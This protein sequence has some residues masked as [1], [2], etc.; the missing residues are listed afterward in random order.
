MKKSCML[1][2]ILLCTTVLLSFSQQAPG[3]GTFIIH[4]E[5]GALIGNS[6]N[7]KKSP[8]IFHSSLNYMLCKNLSAGIGTGVEFLK[9]T[10]LPVTANVLYQFRKNKAIFPFVRLQAGYQVALESATVMDNYNDYYYYSLSS[11]ASSF[12]PYPYYP[13]GEKLDAQG[14]WMINPSV[15]IIVYTHAGLGFSLAAGYRY[16]QLNYAGKDDYTFHAEY[17]RLMLA[18]GITF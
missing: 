18:F 5:G 9:E 13:W 12:Y 15:G 11:S 4:T 7:D 17:N 14:G 6:E 1:T 10:Y 8:F 16:Q 2:G 3:K